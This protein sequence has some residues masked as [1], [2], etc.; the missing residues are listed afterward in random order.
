[1]AKC[2]LCGYESE[3]I[4][5]AIGVCVNCLRKNP[6][7]AL[8]KVMKS[9]FRWRKLINLPS[10]PPQNGEISCKICVNECQILEGNPG[11]CGII[12]NRKGKLVP[13]TGSFDY[14]YLHWYLD[15]H[16]T[17]CVAQP[18]CPEAKHRGFCNLAVFFAGCNL[19]CL[20]CQNIEHKYMIKNGNIDPLAGIIISSEE[21]AN[22]AMK[23]EV[24]C[25]CYFGGDPTPHAPYAIKTS[26]EILKRAKNIESTKRICWETNGLE[27][28]NIMKEMAKLSIE[29]GGIIKIDWK[30]Y[31]PQVYE[32]LTGINGEKALQRIKEN[33]K[34]ISSMKTRNEPPLLVVSTLV[35]PHYIDGEEVRKIATYLAK[36]DPEIPYVLLGFAPQHLMHDVLPTSK[37]Q[38]EEV[39]HAAKE[40]GIKEVYIENYWLLR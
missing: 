32:A 16:P 7:K 21:L 28:P 13:I 15:P 40:E 34:L 2:E 1:M 17:N 33:I 6:Q 38:M 3:E 23:R 20:F 39:Y 30:A 11:Y 22:V 4:S 27:N 9:H 14:G 8:E 25:V 18:V 36:L 31:T 10:L 19:D 26:R 37:K 29:S 24:S 5:E 12:W 35:V